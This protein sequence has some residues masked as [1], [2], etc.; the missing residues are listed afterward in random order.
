MHELLGNEVAGAN[1]LAGVRT[2]GFA[3]KR[4]AEGAVALV[5]HAAEFSVALS[6]GHS[7]EAVVAGVLEH[8]DIGHALAE[9][10]LRGTLRHR[11]EGS[12]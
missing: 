3:A 5:R 9:R 4:G 2:I 10:L 8:Y 6:S 1:D 7:C 12:T 11:F